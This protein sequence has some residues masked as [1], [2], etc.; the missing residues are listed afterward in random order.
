MKVN[1]QEGGGWGN[2]L[3]FIMSLDGFELEKT[4]PLLSTTESITDARPCLLR[5]A[6]ICSRTVTF[7]TE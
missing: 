1:H 3:I 4:Q 5:L 2:G 6:A 7:L